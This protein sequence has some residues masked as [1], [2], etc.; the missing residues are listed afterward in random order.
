VLG[1]ETEALRRAR[2]ELRNL[3]DELNREIARNSRDAVQQPDSEGGQPSRDS[4]RSQRDDKRGG[5]PQDGAAE[6]PPR[7]GAPARSQ[8]Q[9]PS[10]GE[11]AS[12]ESPGE[13][14]RPGET[15][16]SRQPGQRSADRQGARDQQPGEGRSASNDGQPD[17]QTDGHRGG[18]RSP[19]TGASSPRG[20]G[21]DDPTE[22]GGGRPAGGRAERVVAPIAGNDYLDW[23]DRLRDVEE[24]VDDP[25]LRAE[26]ARIRDRA[27]AIRGE[28]KRHSAPPNWDVVRVQIA[29][30]LVELGR[31]ISEELLRRNSRQAVVPLDRDPVPPRYSEKTRRY[32]ENLGSGK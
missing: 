26:A 5:T 13:Q 20:V 12:A 27:R 1:D 7:D 25:D 18:N 22:L 8:G 16:Q 4:S 19:Q 29:E 21:I 15:G 14:G 17:G 6:Q 23:S 10:S 24:M 9:Q 28:V 30:P 2:D 3:S 31:R 11:P 32:Y